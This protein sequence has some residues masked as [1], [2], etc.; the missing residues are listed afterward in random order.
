M[1][2]PSGWQ[3]ASANIDKDHVVLTLRRPDGSSLVAKL[4]DGGRAAKP[5]S[6]LEGTR[7]TDAE[8]NVLLAA[9]STINRA[10][11]ADPFRECGTPSP[12]MTASHR[13]PAKRNDRRLSL[14]GAGALARLA[15]PAVVGLFL[16]VL[17]ATVG[18]PLSTRVRR[19]LSKTS[20]LDPEQGLSLW[21]WGVPMSLA[22]VAAFVR[23]PLMARG[24]SSDE[25]ALLID[26]STWGL[27]A[28]HESGI[29]PPLHRLLLSLGSSAEAGL[30]LGR[31][32]SLLAGLGAVGAGTAL[33]RKG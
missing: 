1:P 26:T 30:L 31:W 18:R 28:G 7:L 27:V 33:R 5:F 22:V 8:R 17:A 32:I 25:V 9:V 24:P 16:L 11:S 12:P 29:N 3:A 23:W 2:L 14:V 4:V 21:I 13:K 6:L 15:I 20:A 10:F 19:W